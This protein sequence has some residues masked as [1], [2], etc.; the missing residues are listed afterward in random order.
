MY[1]MYIYVYNHIS[2]YGLED[3]KSRYR[4]VLITIQE[5]SG[6]HEIAWEMEHMNPRGFWQTCLFFILPSSTPITTG[7]SALITVYYQRMINTNH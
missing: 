4:L 5:V 6:C 7:A 1:V 2:S 3:W